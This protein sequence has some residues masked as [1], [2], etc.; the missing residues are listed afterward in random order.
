MTYGELIQALDKLSF[1]QLEE[2]LVVKI[3]DEYIPVKGLTLSPE[4]DVLDKNHP[5][6]IIEQERV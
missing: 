5:I 6:L 2:N 1:T 4:D 3:G